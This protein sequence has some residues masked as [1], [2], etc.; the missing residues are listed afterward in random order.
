MITVMIKII[1]CLLYSFLMVLMPLAAIGVDIHEAL[2]HHHHHEVSSDHGEEHLHHNHDNVSN[3]VSNILSELVFH[4]QSDHTENHKH[5]KSDSS[6]FTNN[7][8]AD[9]KIKRNSH[10][11]RIAAI[12]SID[13][14]LLKNHYYN[15]IWPSLY[16]KV[17][18][19][20]P[21]HFRSL[22]LLN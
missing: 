13:Y 12:Q 8:S 15:D 7:S 19:P 1:S 11:I 3:E 18:K 6:L 14:Q 17:F 2:S 21:H 4:S 9:N 10:F 22:P 16:D 5:F 20:G